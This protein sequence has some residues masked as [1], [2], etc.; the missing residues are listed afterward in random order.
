MN[1]PD[2]PL[3]IVGYDAEEGIITLGRNL[4]IVVEGDETIVEPV[5]YDPVKGFI[6]TEHTFYIPK[7][8]I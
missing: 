7:E 5:F 8:L 2:T 6:Q 4:I 1:L 3:S